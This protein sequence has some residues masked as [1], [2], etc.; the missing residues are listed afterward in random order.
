VLAPASQPRSLAKN[1][2]SRKE[3]FGNSNSF[4]RSDRSS[5]RWP[6]A[7]A[8]FPSSG[9][10]IFPVTSA[11]SAGAHSAND[12]ER[13]SLSLTPFTSIPSRRPATVLKPIALQFRASFLGHGPLENNPQDAQ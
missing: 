13:R 7:S 8:S 4:Q 1:R 11:R 12:V 3:S 10:S 2:S 9:C 5:E 6:I